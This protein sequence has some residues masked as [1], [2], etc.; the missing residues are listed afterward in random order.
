MSLA[1]TVS[2]SIAIA[3]FTV[4]AV[5]QSTFGEFVGT[6][7]DQSGGLIAGCTVTVRNAGTSATRSTTTDSVGNYTV[8]NLEPGVYEITIAM[9]GF[10]KDVYSNLQLLARQTV[11]VDS[12]LEVGAQEQ[13]VEVS[14][15]KEPPIN[16]EVSNIAETKLGRELVDLPVAIASRA[17]GSTSAITTLTT[18]AGVEIDNSGNISVAGSKPSMLSMSIDGISTMSPRST[19]PIAELFPAFDGIAE[20]RVSEINNTAEFSG[21]N[22]I[23]TIS[24]SGAN[25]FHGGV[26]ENHQNSAFAA[27]NTFSATVP[28]LIMNDFGGF[29]GGPVVVPKLYSGKNKMFFFLTYE[30]LRLPR[31]T[32]LTES[33]PSIALRGGDLSAYLPKAV[34]DLSGNPFP[35]NQIPLSTIAPVSLNAL[36]YLFPLPNTGSPGAISNNFVE[37][38]PSPISSNQGDVRLDRNISSK[39]SAFARLT[40]KRRQVTNA[41][42][43]SILTGPNLAP[44]ND[45]SLTGA[46]NYILN[47]RM[48]NEF[49]V[50][51][52]GS[53]AASIPGESAS[54]I[55]GQVGISPYITQD[56]TGVNTN[57]NFKISGFQST[58][59]SYSS[60][61]NTQTFQFLDNLTMNRGR[62]T[63]KFGGDYRYLTAL[64]T[65]AFGF[66]FLGVYTFNNSVTS[67]I[68]NPYGAFLLGVPDATTLARCLQPNTQAYAS[69]Y[70][71]Y[72]QDDW[73]V[74]PRLTVNYGV[75]WEYH[76]M[77]GDHLYNTA[78]LLPNYTSVINGKTVMGAVVVADKGVPEVDPD[79]AAS[80]APTPIL[81][82]SQV[83]LPQTL[84]YSQK[85]DFAPRFGFA[86]RVTGDGKT[87]IRAGIGKYIE[88][89]LG[90][91]V[92][93]AWGVE[94]SDTAQFTNSISN[95]QAQLTLPYPFPANLA[96]PGSQAFQYSFELHY[97]DPYVEQ[98]NF[99]IERDLGFQTGLR[100]SYDGSHGRDLAHFDDL[101]QVPANTVGY[102]VAKQTGP[103]PLWAAINNYTNGGVSNYQSLTLSL[104]KHLSRGL[105]FNASY[106]YSKNLSDIGG[107]NPT[108]FAGAGGGYSTDTYDAYLDYGNVPYTR[109]QRLLAT[110]LYETSTHTGNRAID[111]AASGWELAGVLTFQKGAFLTVIVPGADPSGTNFAN[112]YDNS[113]GA[114][115]PD[116]V[117]GVSIAPVNQNIHQWIN[118]AAFV[119]PKNNIGRF[120]DDPVGNVVGPGTEAVNLSFYRS[121][122]LKEH[123]AFRVGASASNLFNHPNYGV[124][125]LVLG[126]APFGTI[127]SLQ[128]AEGAGPRA[129]QLG[130]RLTF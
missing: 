1:R 3:V 81:T 87:V 71:L 126:T 96:Q 11:R 45:W 89:T 4:V 29:V 84:R 112:A 34:K 114:S 69:S 91:L 27:R 52:T 124:P 5:A 53:H 63:L 61:N 116:V 46:D 14:A 17:L 100:V 110:F 120:G 98:W 111:L 50:G 54:V 83:G 7:K 56:L 18:Q 55:A 127:S 95:G 123:A 48:V 121:F 130:A 94:S 40:Y 38:Y 26:F 117:S 107:Y 60:I 115:R 6:V 108:S 97:K 77:F 118:A 37:N 22:D 79:F 9:P 67:A 88:T 78:N 57:P 64:F 25:M 59:G 92:S 99:T 125:N 72:A 103:Y 85:T 68:G 105:Q 73:K 109:R 44:E 23:T 65:D 15:A 2:L 70:A 82:A 8:V 43:A 31:Q 51:W 12:S 47:P 66:D 90:Q 80:I 28:K 104:N 35:N 102:A 30:G 42:S 36:K 58:G 21:I 74:T 33:V 129:L 76:P 20:I 86:W 128:S 113:T 24:K 41:P 32:V 49:R 119:T 75:R 13:S 62:H 19:A 93:G 39:H 122:K 10:R 101:T 16:T 106:N